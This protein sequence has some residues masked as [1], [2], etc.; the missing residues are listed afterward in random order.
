[1]NNELISRIKQLSSHYYPETI[2]NRR[3]FHQ[4]PELSFEEFNTSLYI[5]SRLEEMGIPFRGCAQGTGIIA[6]LEG[7]NPEGKVIALRADMD[8]LPINEKTGVDFASKIPGKM[9]ACGHD[10]HMASLLCTARVLSDLKHLWSGTILLVF[11]PGEEKFPGGASL[12]INEG[13]LENPKPE[14]VIGQHVLPEMKSG[15]FGFRSGMYMASGD[16]VHIC[17]TGKGGHA[18]LPHLL[19]DP[20]LA[21]SH[22]VVALQQIVSRV[23]PA[24]V[25][26]VLSFG[27]IE[28][29]GATNV[30]PDRVRLA[31]TL[32]TMDSKWR[33]ILKR[34]IRQTAISV[35]EAM[36]CSCEV[37]IK[38]GYP[39][40]YN[41]ED[42]NDAMQKQAKEYLG[43]A[44]VE[45]MD[46]RMTSEDFGYYSQVFPSNFYR[47]GVKQ[48]DGSTGELHTPL[49]NLN[50][51]SLEHAPGL[52]AWMTIS[53]LNA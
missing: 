38:D 41:N 46:I 49:F 21:A 16:E 12:L 33:E 40:V 52:M 51:K 13:A 37:D 15:H 10:A 48:E 27:F 39:V 19:A 25:P 9:H 36:G 30:I 50:E 17:I 3:W 7:V 43:E 32:R 29:K 23:V 2:I 20:V 42:L 24:T 44:C 47:F 53:L 1:M 11:Q 18:A 34:K 26:T 5:S 14:Y 45:K 6:T 4:N 28:G 8:A 22:V 31:G 35:S